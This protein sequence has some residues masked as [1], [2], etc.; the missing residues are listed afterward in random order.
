MNKTVVK[1][2]IELNLISV[3]NDSHSVFLNFS[4]RDLTGDRIKKDMELSECTPL[5]GWSG[6]H[7]YDMIGFDEETKTAYFKVEGEIGGLLP[8]EGKL[9]VKGIFSDFEEKAYTENIDLTEIVNMNPEVKNMGTEAEP[10]YYL[11]SGDL[12]I[13]VADGEAVITNVGVVNGDLHIMVKWE[14]IGK[15]ETELRL[16]ENPDKL[17]LG[18]EYGMQYGD[19][20]KVN[21]TNKATGEAAELVTIGGTCYFDDKKDG[22]YCEYVIEA[23]GNGNWDDFD[24]NNLGDYT[25][26]LTSKKSDT[27]SKTLSVTYP[28]VQNATLQIKNPDDPRMTLD[29]SPTTVSL[30]DETVRIEYERYVEGLANGAAEEHG[31]TVNVEIA[32][33]NGEVISLDQMDFL[34]GYGSDWGKDCD[35]SLKHSTIYSDFGKTINLEDIKTVTYNG[36]VLYK[37]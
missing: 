33:K 34:N 4:L 25:L 6:G 15:R 30:I 23:D 26:M 31:Y 5:S 36:K 37:K 22:L 11:K 21:F 19:H 28:I 16:V 10:S 14:K 20:G 18:L 27:K 24:V 12:N 2:G 3:R 35:L 32:F 7:G 9:A 1:D 17:D 8:N 13:P 29:I